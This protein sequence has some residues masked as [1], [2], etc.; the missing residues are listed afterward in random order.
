MQSR[1]VLDRQEHVL[2]KNKSG[3]LMLNLRSCSSN[4]LLTGSDKYLNFTPNYFKLNSLSDDITFVDVYV[5]R[6][7]ERD[8]TTS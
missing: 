7:N 3:N 4:K 6:R 2:H 8:L 1:L 5:L